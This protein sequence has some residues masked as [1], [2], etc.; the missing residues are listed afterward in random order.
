M[1]RKLYTK[2]LRADLLKEVAGT[3]GLYTAEEHAR[4]V[5]LES[6]ER[7]RSRETLL[8]ASLSEN[9]EKL[10]ALGYLIRHAGRGDFRGVLS[11]GAG[12]CVLEYLLKLSLPESVRVVATDFNPYLIDKAKLLLPGIMPATFDFHK[13]RVEDLR[14][15]LGVD[16][17]LAVFFGSAYVMDDEQFIRLFQGLKKIGVKQVIDF[18]AGFMDWKALLSNAAGPLRG[19]APLRRLLGKPPLDEEFLGKFHG[20]TRSRGEL[21]RLYKLGGVASFRELEAGPYK[22]TAV[23]EF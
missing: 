13:D 4:V 9:A 14:K 22:Y 23:C 20:Y 2:N 5:E 11:L 7:F 1:K 12:D 6:A 8:R 3:G 21:R 16:F 10:A 17:D 18:H 15:T 19:F